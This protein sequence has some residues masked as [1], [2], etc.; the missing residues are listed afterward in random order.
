MKTWTNPEVEELEVELTAGGRPFNPFEI[1]WG[2]LTPP[3]PPSNPG[4]G[5]EDGGDETT[6]G[7]S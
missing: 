2:G 4:D 3:S 7:Q 6:D 1:G 5:E